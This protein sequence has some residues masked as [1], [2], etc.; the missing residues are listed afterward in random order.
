MITNIKETEDIEDIEVYPIPFDDEIL[1]KTNDLFNEE[2][3]EIQLLNIEGQTRKIVYAKEF[4]IKN[5]AISI[6]TDELEK[7][8]Y[9]MKIITNNKIYNKQ[10]IKY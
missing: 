9:F 7:G 2:I 3:T 1:I 6:K 8:A 4:I 5:N 10:L